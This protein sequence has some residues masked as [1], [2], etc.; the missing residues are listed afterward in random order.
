MRPWK[1]RL[2][3]PAPASELPPLDVT[4]AHTS[5]GALVAIAGE[6]DV[7]T[8]PR[9]SAAL[10]AE[11]AASAGAIVV[12]LAGVT[13]IDSTGLGALVK[14]E[15]ALAARAGRLAIACP[16]GP[17]RLLFDVTGLAEQLS[18][19]ATRAE[20]EASITA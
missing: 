3:E 1:K 5:Y 13:F 19:C 2:R 17:A 11:P 14:L 9:V 6:V 20:A 15:H 8:V 12:D 18:V 7:A 10:E 4:V 16:E